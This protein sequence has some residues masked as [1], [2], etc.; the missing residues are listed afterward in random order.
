MGY[1]AGALGCHG[2]RRDTKAGGGRSG[3]V[4]PGWMQGLTVM[5]WYDVKNHTIEMRQKD[6]T[7]KQIHFKCIEQQIPVSKKEREGRPARP[8]EKKFFS[9]LRFS[10]TS[11]VPSTDSGI[12]SRGDTRVS[13]GHQVHPI[14]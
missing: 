7:E 1:A 12:P 6:T 3:N 14:P 4:A 8:C 9:F 10:T 13:L 5:V 11:G 2:R